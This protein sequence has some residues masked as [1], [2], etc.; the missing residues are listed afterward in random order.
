MLFVVV[1]IFLTCYSGYNLSCL[2]VDM[3]YYSKNVQ[4]L[5][6]ERAQALQ[7]QQALMDTM[8]QTSHSIANSSWHWSIQI[9][10]D[11]FELYSIII[12]IIFIVCANYLFNEESKYNILPN[13][14]KQ[15]S[16]T[17][18]NNDKIVSDHEINNAYETLKKAKQ[19]ISNY[20]KLNIRSN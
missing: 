10:P 7:R 20:N 17:T 3:L 16:Q 4:E 11:R 2:F 13:K 18:A 12:T 15:L 8:M 19:Q 1:V 9:D 5:D 6:F 14:Y